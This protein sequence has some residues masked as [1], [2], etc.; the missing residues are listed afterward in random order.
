MSDTAAKKADQEENPHAQAVLKLAD[1]MLRATLIVGLGTIAV[2]AVVATIWVGLPG[3]LG[4]LVGGAVAFAS[5]L[6]TIG[7]MRFCAAMDPMFVM[8]VALA[9]YVVKVLILLGVMT[10][11]RGVD[12]LH[13]YALAITMLA[14]FVFTAAGEVRAFKQTKIPTII[15]D[16]K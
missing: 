5:S 9:S 15:P 2:A 4:A 1:A 10:L 6:A 14:A 16:S 11:L 3:L 13:P 8:M 12:A 7:M